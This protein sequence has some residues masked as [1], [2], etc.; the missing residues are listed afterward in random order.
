MSQYY[1]NL[2]RLVAAELGVW[3]GD[4]KAFVPSSPQTG[5]HANLVDFTLIRGLVHDDSWLS[6]TSTR[7][8]TRRVR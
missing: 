4:R 7:V 1:A 5:R 2:Q 8:H 3:S 6:T